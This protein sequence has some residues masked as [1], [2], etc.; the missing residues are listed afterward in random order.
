MGSLGSRFFVTVCKINIPEMIL[1]IKLM[2]MSTCLNQRSTQSRLKSLTSA[3]RVDRF[4]AVERRDK[5]QMM[6]KWYGTIVFIFA[7]PTDW[8]PMPVTIC[9]SEN[10]SSNFRA[11]G[12]D[13]DLRRPKRMIIEASKSEMQFVIMKERRT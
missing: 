1:K 10:P 5:S 13:V 7:R 2:T 4:V 12:A 6:K 3:S 8:I 9:W 11:T